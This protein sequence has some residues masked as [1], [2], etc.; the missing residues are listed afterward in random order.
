MGRNAA[1]DWHLGHL[2][3]QF[4]PLE[5]YE[6]AAETRLEEEAAAASI[7]QPYIGMMVVRKI[8]WER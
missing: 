8:E 5:S 1:K 7:P 6:F 4:F 2:E 3:L